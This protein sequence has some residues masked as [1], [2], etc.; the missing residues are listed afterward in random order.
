MRGGSSSISIILLQLHD[1]KR[2][3]SQLESEKDSLEQELLNVDTLLREKR[4]RVEAEHARTKQTE[5]T[6]A[7]LKVKVRAALL[8]SFKTSS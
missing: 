6:V 8:I 1:L 5:E 7:A 2:K 3:R 4:E